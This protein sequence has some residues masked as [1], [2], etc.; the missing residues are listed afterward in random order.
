MPSLRQTK[1]VGQEQAR[2]LTPPHRP[3]INAK[4]DPVDHLCVQPR[5][6]FGQDIQANM[7]C[8]F[9]YLHREV[10]FVKENLRALRVAIVAVLN[11]SGRARLRVSA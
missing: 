1:A 4:H 3:Q 11:L 5:L 9:R 6:R 7:Q 10:P 8:Q 2:K